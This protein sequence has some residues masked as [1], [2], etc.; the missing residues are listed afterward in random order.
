M[1]FRK[2]NK[3]FSWK[4][5]GFIT[6]RCIQ[7]GNEYRKL[8]GVWN[9]GKINRKYVGFLLCYVYTTMWAKGW[10]IGI[11]GQEML[12]KGITNCLEGSKQPHWMIRIL[13]SGILIWQ[14]SFAFKNSLRL[15]INFS[16]NQ[17]R[18]NFPQTRAEEKTHSP[19]T[20]S[21]KSPIF[22]HNAY[23]LDLQL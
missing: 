11:K 20:T 3:G 19:Q 1:F 10:E 16:S 15:L 22:L 5:N 7:L 8:P 17:G 14:K 12:F 6:E 13:P 9:S 18:K 4:L 2:E 21:Q 23:E